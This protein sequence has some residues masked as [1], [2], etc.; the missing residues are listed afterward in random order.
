M[1]R[2]RD[3]KDITKRDPERESQCCEMESVG[4]YSGSICYIQW[5]TE[6][7]PST[8][9]KGRNWNT[10]LGHHI[11]KNRLQIPDIG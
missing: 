7:L 10:D 4:R 6:Q 2:D 3:G 9:E 8:V 5:A 1:A 11:E